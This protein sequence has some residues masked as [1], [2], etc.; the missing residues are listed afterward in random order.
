MFQ[1]F[2]TLI[3]TTLFILI[4]SI[5]I[6]F[7][8]IYIYSN[9]NS[10]NF[11]NFIWPAPGY[12]TITSKFGKR[13]APTTGASTYHKGLDISAP[14]GTPLLAVTSGKITFTG[15]LGAGGCTITLTTENLKISYCHVSPDYIVQEG[16]I[17]LK[18]QII[19]YVGPKYV[20]NIPENTYFDKYGN[21]TNGATTGP[22]L[23]IGFR[24]NNNYVNPLNYIT[25]E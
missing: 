12:Y 16:D 15:F 2:T 8:P 9:T 13:T 18:G 17:V 4:L 20:Y 3:F 25:P 24:L 14:T 5:S 10:S 22:H 21:P 23:H 7:S 6:F 11:S 1:K 19:G